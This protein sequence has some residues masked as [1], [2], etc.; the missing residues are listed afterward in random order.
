MSEPLCFFFSVDVIEV[1]QWELRKV[2]STVAPGRSLHSLSIMSYGEGVSREKER[3]KDIC[4][5]ITSL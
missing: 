4:E 1:Q 5:L 3:V 2:S